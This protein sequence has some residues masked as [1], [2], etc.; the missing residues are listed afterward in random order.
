[1]PGGGKEPWFGN[2]I[3]RRQGMATGKRLTGSEKVRQLQDGVICE[4]G[5]KN[6]DGASTR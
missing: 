5:R 1:M 3:G 4:S 2:D 6:P